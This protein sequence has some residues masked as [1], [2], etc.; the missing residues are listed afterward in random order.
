[1]I[2]EEMEIEERRLLDG[3]DIR[4]AIIVEEGEL[5]GVGVDANM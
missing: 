2:V 3:N 5:G 1:M 4:S